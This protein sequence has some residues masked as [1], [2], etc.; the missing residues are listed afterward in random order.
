M[1]YPFKI[2]INDQQC[3]EQIKDDVQIGHYFVFVKH[4]KANSVERLRRLLVKKYSKNIVLPLVN[5]AVKLDGVTI[6]PEHRDIE[7]I[8]CVV[9]DRD[10]YR[11]EQ[12][13]VRLFI[14]FPTPPEDLRLTIN[15][16][17]EVFSERRVKLMDGVGIETL[18]MLPPGSYEAQLSIASHHICVPASFTVAEDCLAP[19]SAHLFKHKFKE[20]AATFLFELAVESYQMPFEGKLL[21]TLVEQGLEVADIILKPVTPGRYVGRIPMSGPGPFSL[22]LRVAGDAKRVADVAIPCCLQV[23]DEKATVISEL[24]EERC[25]SMMP[26]ADALPLRGGYLFQDDFFAAPLT[27]EEIVTNDRFIQ[28]NSDVESLILVNLDLTSG[29]YVIQD[30]GDV[31]AGNTVRVRT[32]SPFCTVFVGGFV[33]DEAF[34]GYTTFIKPCSF[35]LNVDAI[36]AGTDLVVRLKGIVDK[37]IPVLLCVRDERVTDNPGVSLGAAAK[38][39]IDA[40][41]EG[42][43]KRAFS[44]MAELLDDESEVVTSFGTDDGDLIDINAELNDQA[45]FDLAQWFLDMGETDTAQ[46]IIMECIAKGNLA[47]NGRAEE[48]LQVISGEDISAYAAAKKFGIPLLDL[49]SVE[50]KPDLIKLV[51]ENLLR[52]RKALPLFKR[53]DF[54]F[55]AISDPSDSLDEIQSCTQMQI[56]AILVEA[57]ILESFIE[58]AFEFDQSLYEAIEGDGSVTD[59]LSSYLETFTQD[60]DSSPVDDLSSYL[61]TFTQE[62]P[63]DEL[64]RYLETFSQE[65]EDEL[66]PEEELSEYLDDLSSGEYLSQEDEFSQYLDTFS[67]D[68]ESQTVLSL[69]D[70]SQVR[71]YQTHEFKEVLYYQIVHVGGSTEV[72]I[73]LGDSQG[74]FSVETFAMMDGDWIQSHSIVNVEQ[75]VRVDFDLPSVVYPG[76]KVVGH[77]N[78]VISSGK[79][80]ISLMRNGESVALCNG[81]LIEALSVISPVNL[82]FYVQPGSYVAKIED[83][84]FE[85]VVNEPGKFNCYPK[86]LGLLFKDDSIIKDSSDVLS[87]RVL[88]TIDTF[89]NRLITAIASDCHEGCEPTAAKILAAT[90]MYLTVDELRGTAE[91]LILMG[92][93]HEQ[94][95][96]RPGLGFAVYPESDDVSE[97]LSRCTVRYLWHLK[98]LE[99][100]SDI[101]GPLRKAVR[102]GLSLA[103]KAAEAHQMLPL[104]EQI[105]SIEDAYACVGIFPEAVLQFVENTIDF[106]GACLRKCEDAVRDRTTLAY[107]AACLIALGDLRR[108]ISLAN[109]VTRQFNE[110][111]RFFS[112][113]DSVAAIVLLSGIVMREARVRVN[114]QEMRAS[115]AALVEGPIDS[116]EVLEGFAAVEVRRVY[117]ENWGRYADNFPVSVDFRDAGDMRVEQVGAGDRIDLVVSLPEGC[118]TGD[119]VEVALPCSLSWTRGGSKVKRFTLDFEGQD[120]LRIPLVVTSPIDGE[121]HFALCV[122]NIFKEERVASL[123]MVVHIVPPKN[124]EGRV[125]PY[126]I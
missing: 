6:T 16:N 67:L 78:A 40:A 62:F 124:V 126:L 64:S 110:E 116:I 66:S 30:E 72:V 14:A 60:E 107:A 95:M 88:P 97:S 15:C 12:D 120:E 50:L 41:I 56:E 29:H 89:F 125:F 90:F 20:D 92:V 52:K 112:T 73:P 22:R 74:S 117:E 3:A 71:Y 91:Q 58:R 111:G 32:D 77:L 76:D 102:Q 49:D 23:V 96:I 115:E 1:K 85:F 8:G 79:A 57:D 24:G 36:R 123:G 104:P 81:E 9:T 27:V 28:V 94:K 83:C 119:L 25:F 114:G 103:N 101:S 2:T 121:Q 38:R 35:Q 39:G 109:V 5:Q 55:V 54:L 45:K 46:N 33:D 84:S 65:D 10:L 7:P 99:E 44:M 53:G 106:S 4:K 31:A 21:V 51:D 100:F 69:S 82:D 59:E 98:A 11:A 48:M 47:E 80:V 87:L 75:P 43:D 108:G 34:E 13:S 63:E 26:E 118:Q 19:L 70:N 122:R 17:G 61:E 86:E 18:S 37:T 93:A 113:M 42:M 105:H 68:E